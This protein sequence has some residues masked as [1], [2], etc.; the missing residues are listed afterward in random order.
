MSDEPITWDNIPGLTDEERRAGR[1][2]LAIDDLR[3]VTLEGNTVNG[4]KIP[5]MV[6][7]VVVR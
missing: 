7:G 4:V 3:S 6:Y 5:P 2:L 1:N